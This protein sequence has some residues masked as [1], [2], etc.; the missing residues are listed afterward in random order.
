MGFECGFPALDGG[1][2]AE[3]KGD[4]GRHPNW[5]MGLSENRVN[6]NE[7]AIFHRDMLG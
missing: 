4:I 5:Q 7:I 6:P 3:L 2:A 1:A